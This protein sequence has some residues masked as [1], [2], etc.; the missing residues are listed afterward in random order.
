MYIGLY[1]Y[2][3]IYIYIY[4]LTCTR[5]YVDIVHRNLGLYIYKYRHGSVNLCNKLLPAVRVDKIIISTD[6]LLLLRAMLLII[7]KLVDRVTSYLQRTGSLD[8]CGVGV[9]VS[10]WFRVI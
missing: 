10:C 3:Y 6:I 8:T 1:I 9:G 5:R 4:Y 7:C 2:I